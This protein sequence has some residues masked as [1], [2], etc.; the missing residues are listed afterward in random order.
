MFSPAAGP[1][2]HSLGAPSLNQPLPSRW[3]DGSRCFFT[4][5]RQQ[6][7]VNTDAKV[8]QGSSN[9]CVCINTHNS[10]NSV[11]KPSMQLSGKFCNTL[12][13][14]RIKIIRKRLRQKI[15]KESGS[16]RTEPTVNSKL[17]TVSLPT[18]HLKRC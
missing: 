12:A 2:A 17:K 14:W 15:P 16:P 5:L 3:V 18:F 6:Q 11:S 1:P 10:L 4:H 13:A 8:R 9:A 7:G